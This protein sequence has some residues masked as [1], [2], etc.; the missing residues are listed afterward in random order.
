MNLVVLGL[1]FDIVGVSI[2]LYKGGKLERKKVQL[3]KIV[4]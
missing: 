3:V 4:R 1:I 2:W